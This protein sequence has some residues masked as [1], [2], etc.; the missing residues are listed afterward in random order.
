[1]PHLK[2]GQQASQVASYR[3]PDKEFHTVYFPLPW[4]RG[5]GGGGISRKCEINYLKIYI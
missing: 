1:M 4:G 5:S 2:A 3:F